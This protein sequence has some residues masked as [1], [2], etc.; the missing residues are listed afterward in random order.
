M[1]PAP[2]LDSL[3]RQSGI[4]NP[5]AHCYRDLAGCVTESVPEIVVVMTS[6]MATDIDALE[7]LAPLDPR[8]LG[9]MGSMAKIRHIKHALRERYVSRNTINKIH[10]PVGLPMK[11]DTPA[12]IAVSVVAQLLSLKG[13][14]G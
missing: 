9:V 14:R 11:S 6:A 12:E 2:V 3:E 4:Q 10:G 13:D 8:W 5:L 7:V 1:T